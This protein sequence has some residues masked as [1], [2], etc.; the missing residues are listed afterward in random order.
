[1]EIDEYRERVAPRKEQELR[2]DD[3][4]AKTIADYYSKPQTDT[5]FNYLY[6]EPGAPSLDL[7]EWTRDGIISNYGER[8]Q[9]K[10]M[11]CVEELRIL[12]MMKL[13]AEEKED[14]DLIVNFCEP[15]I[16]FN[17]S[18]KAALENTS[19][20]IGGYGGQLSK[21]NF[22]Y[23]QQDRRNI[24]SIQ[25]QQKPGMFSGFKLPKVGGGGGE[26]RMVGTGWS[27]V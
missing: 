1:M 22:N 3:D 2:E 20:N 23:V 4:T 7:G 14:Y 21:S 9:N 18:E 8:T 15:L 24:D 13:D 16:R 6:V 17:V 27:S 19:R 10:I 11:W 5:Q 12:E 26:N 25:Q